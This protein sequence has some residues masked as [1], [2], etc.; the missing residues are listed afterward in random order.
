MKLCKGCK[1]FRRINNCHRIVKKRTFPDYVMGSLETIKYD[2][3]LNADRERTPK[4]FE[5]WK[6]GKGARYWEAK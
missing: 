3:V 4:W 1:H 6:C 2:Y 5:F